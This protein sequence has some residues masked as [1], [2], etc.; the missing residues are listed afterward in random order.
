MIESRLAALAAHCFKRSFRARTSLHSG[1][2]CLSIVHVVI[3]GG[4]ADGDGEARH[5]LCYLLLVGSSIGALGST[6][7]ISASVSFQDASE[8]LR[9][10]R[11]RE[12]R[13]GG[14]E[15]RGTRPSGPRGPEGAGD[16]AC[17]RHESTLEA[18]KQ[19]KV[20]VRELILRVT[21]ELRR[22][23]RLPARAVRE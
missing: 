14:L 7:E 15:A 16:C 4:G 6:V 5:R 20:Q 19:L 2:A 1:S 13:D 10:R 12:A 11:D 18:S 8:R 17:G 23:S 22:S 21:A 9:R 3:V